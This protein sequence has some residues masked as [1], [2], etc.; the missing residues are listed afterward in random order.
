LT[1]T[2]EDNT[3]PDKGEHLSQL[4]T[5]AG[6]IVNDEIELGDVIKRITYI[7]E[8]SPVQAVSADRLP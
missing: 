8:Y 2:I 7:S 4:S 3:N 6:F 5:T 1:E